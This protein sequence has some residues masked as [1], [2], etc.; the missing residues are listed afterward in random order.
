M[1]YLVDTCVLLRFVNPADVDHND[2]VEAVR[3]LS[4]RG[5]KLAVA[6]QNVAEFWNVC[7]RPV[8]AR[9]GY[10]LTVE[11]A[12]QKL[13]AI[14]LVFSVL[15]ESPDT[16]KVWRSLVMTHQVQGVKV[17]DARL[18]ALMQV[19]A[20]DRIL[21]LNRDDFSRY[22]LIRAIT[23]SEVLQELNPPRSPQSRP[24]AP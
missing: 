13:E 10:G 20:V 21:T 23:P 8:S 7:T 16:Y 5:E 18:V 12:A 22:T 17:H 14:E 1:R 9:G 6:P 11:Q 3:G 2:I 24:L 19:L 15:P 4:G